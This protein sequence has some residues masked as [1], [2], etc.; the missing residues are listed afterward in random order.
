MHKP[1][2]ALTMGDPAGVGPEI[3]ARACLHPA[4]REA[5]LPVVVG[6]AEVLRRAVDECGADAAVRTVDDVAQARS[7]E[8]DG[9]IPCLHVGDDDVLA[10]PRAQVDARSG[11]AAYEAVVAATHLA[12]SGDV[13]GIVTAPLHKEALAAAGVKHPGHTELLAELC[14]V[15]QFAMMLYLASGERVK[16]P[17]GLGVAHV[18][19]HMAFRDVL[20]HLTESAVIEKIRLCD[21]VLRRFGAEKPRIGVAALNPHAGEQG[22][23]GDEEGRIIADG[24]HNDVYASCTRYRTLYDFQTTLEH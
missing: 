8:T 18:T 12:L 13:D 7:S 5:C 3:V 2:L 14:G 6:H 11:R 4:V 20:A 9:E 19:L 24:P 22:L 1:F 15:E 23:F 10:A 21:D 17:H 16:S